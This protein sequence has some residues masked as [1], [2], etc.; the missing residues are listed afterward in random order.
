MTDGQ[1]NAVMHKCKDA[2]T[3]LSKEDINSNNA[4]ILNLKKSENRM[5][6]LAACLAL[7]CP[8]FVK[9]GC[10]AGQAFA[11]LYF[12]CSNFHCCKIIISSASV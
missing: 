6:F 8:V 11:A 4:E 5:H 12:C 7:T 3:S 9:A 1:E 10:Q 2:I